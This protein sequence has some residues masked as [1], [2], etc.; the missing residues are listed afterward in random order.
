MLIENEI[1]VG[2]HYDPCLLPDYGSNLFCH[3]EAMLVQHNVR[4]INLH[5]IPFWEFY[6]KL[7]A[8]TMVLCDVMLHMYQMAIP[9]VSA[10]QPKMRKIS[11]IYLCK[12]CSLL[13][14][15]DIQ[16]QCGDHQGHCKIGSAH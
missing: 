1:Y 12:T 10:G 9:N 3:H 6:H 16:N 8:S 5:L 11:K 13:T 14:I 15:S 4:D 7:H 2:A